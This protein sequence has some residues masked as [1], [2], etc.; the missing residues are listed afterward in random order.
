MKQVV[1]CGGV[2]GVTP[3]SRLWPVRVSLFVFLPVL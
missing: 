2:D 1:V 3:E